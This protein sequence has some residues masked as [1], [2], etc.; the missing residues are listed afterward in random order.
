MRPHPAPSPR[1]LLLP[2]AP[3]SGR[4]AAVVAAIRHRLASRE[5]APGEKL[6]SV[7][8]F[9]AATGVSPST[10][11]EAYDRL[12]A[13]GLIQA[14]PG[15]GFFVSGAP[16]T[17]PVPDPEPRRDRAID[18][19]WVSRQT[20]D[21][22]PAIPKPGCGWL[23]ADWLPTPAIR[24]ALRQ[25]QRA[26]DALLAD[27]GPSHGSPVLRRLLLR[28]FAAEGL[29]IGPEQLLL[30]ASATQ[31]LDLL[32]RSLLRPGDSV[33]LD[34]P[35]YFNFRALLT[36]HGVRVLGLPWTSDGPDLSRFEQLLSA[37]RPRLY[38]TNSALQNP[39]GATLPP[40]AAHRLLIAAAAHD[41]TIVEDDILVPFEPEPSPRLVLL[42]GLVR[43]VRIGGFSKTL[44]S[45]I[46][47]GY[48]A[49][50]AD[51]V[52]ALADLQVATGFGGS[53]PLAAGLVATT[54]SDPAYRRH[55][56]ALRARLS[57]ARRETAARLV[58]LGVVPW[59]VPRGGFYLWC[60]L[61]D[62][63]DAARLAR[64]ALRRDLLLAPGDVFSP[65]RSTGGF[66]RFNVAQM[67]APAV[68][69]TLAQAIADTR[70][71]PLPA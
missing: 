34:D 65:S 25:A 42:D 29:P 17:V 53:G 67:T 71:A 70:T 55:L 45:S 23:P 40:T 47:C 44:S 11:V 14:R 26:D 51:R 61:P 12:S 19:L 32:C 36:V 1:A 66:M 27:Y 50:S 62:G 30:T 7:R 57:R 46:R 2:Q 6:P 37:H 22:D 68:F 21:A 33:I 54:L 63:L 60:R 69:D 31:A 8:S 4:T 16:A 15:S 28:Q 58:P 56:D 48:L 52:E 59:S 64:A 9:A 41:L 20:L 49:A 35:C 38:V 24:R 13:D 3:R 5:L 39:T 43:T 18:P 10:V